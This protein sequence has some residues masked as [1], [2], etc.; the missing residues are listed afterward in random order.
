MMGYPKD[1]TK[2]SSWTKQ[3]NNANKQQSSVIEENQE[4]TTIAPKAKKQVK[5]NGMHMFMKDNAGKDI[6]ETAKKWNALSQEEKKEYTHRAHEY[7]GKK[8]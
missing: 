2:S 4:S 3:T 6:R 5:L 1:W 7:N 8:Q